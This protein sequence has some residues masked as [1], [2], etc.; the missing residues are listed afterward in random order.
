MWSSPESWL[1]ALS[2]H[3]VD[4][5]PGTVTLL[6]IKVD[7]SLHLAIF[8]SLGVYFYHSIFF[9]ISELSNLQGHRMLFSKLHLLIAAR[10]YGCTA[11]Q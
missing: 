2:D 4:N 1:G 5:N 9:S 7:P 6:V 10:S 3:S 11:Y 8:H